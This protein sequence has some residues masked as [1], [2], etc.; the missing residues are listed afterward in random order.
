VKESFG[1]AFVPYLVDHYQTI[2]VIDYRYWDGNL[3]DFVRKN[4]VQDVIFI[5]N[6]SAIRSTYLM[7]KLQGIV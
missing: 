1:N 3:A 7:G 4:G 5:N 6:L 2:H